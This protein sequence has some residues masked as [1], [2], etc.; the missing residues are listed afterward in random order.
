MD[1]AE[2]Q[3]QQK[4]AMQAPYL[5]ISAIE[6]YMEKSTVSFFDVRG[7]AV[8]AVLDMYAKN[9]LTKLDK[10]IPLTEADEIRFRAAFEVAASAK[11]N[12]TSLTRYQ[13]D[14]HR[15]KFIQHSVAEK[16]A[17]N[18]MNAQKRKENKII[19]KMEADL[20]VTAAGSIEAESFEDAL[21]DELGLDTS[22]V[23]AKPYDPDLLDETLLSELGGDKDGKLSWKSDKSPA[24][25]EDFLKTQAVVPYNDTKND[26]KTT[27]KGIAVYMA[28]AAVVALLIGLGVSAFVSNFTNPVQ[29]GADLQTATVEEN[30]IVTPVKQKVNVT[31]D[32][33]TVQVAPKVEDKLMIKAASIDERMGDIKPMAKAD[34]PV[35]PV[36]KAKPV[37]STASIAPVTASAVQIKAPVKPKVTLTPAAKEKVVLASTDRSKVKFTLPKI[38]TPLIQEGFTKDKPLNGMTLS[39]GNTGFQTFSKADSIENSFSKAE[40]VKEEAKTVKTEKPV[41]ASFVP[42]DE[43]SSNFKDAGAEKPYEVAAFGALGSGHEFTPSDSFLK[44]F[45]QAASEKPYEVAALKTG[46]ASDAMTFTPNE[47]F[48]NA[49]EN[50]AQE[51]PSKITMTLPEMASNEIEPSKESILETKDTWDSAKILIS[52]FVKANGANGKISEQMNGFLNKMDADN[53]KYKGHREMGAFD[54]AKALKKAFGDVAMPVVQKVWTLS[55]N[56]QGKASR[57]AKEGLKLIQG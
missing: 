33:V 37:V 22:R 52:D 26:N 29:G 25:I 11:D 19:A 3:R 48:A 50:V 12:G 57:L 18:F 7:G 20:A 34:T 35:T 14:K 55:A 16:A 24:N 41:P 27:G 56:G 53:A 13:F 1:Y 15:K 30:V 31:P 39:N 10:D 28:G 21:M 36:A 2:Q 5:K 42:S 40:P 8:F 38:K 17:E 54:A 51:N 46:V 45:G 9:V 43:F 6:D 32:A 49:F 4:E 47:A 23:E 44:E